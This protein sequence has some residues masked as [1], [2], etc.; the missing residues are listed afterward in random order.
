MGVLP[1]A[2][3]DA[4]FRARQFGWQLNDKGEVIAKAP[5]GD[6]GADATTPLRPKDWVTGTLKQDAKHLFKGHVGGGATGSGTDKTDPGY[7][8]W[9]KETWNLTEQSK[10]FRA[11]PDRARTLARQAGVTLPATAA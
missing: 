7:N 9:K 5:N 8:P 4:L 2:I 6:Y 10:I 3:S 11:D 1:E